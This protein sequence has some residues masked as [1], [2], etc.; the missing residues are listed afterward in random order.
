MPRSSR[1]T[2][3]AARWAVD[4][5]LALTV[6]ACLLLAVGPMLLGYRTL[7]M[8]SGSMRPLIP[9]GS[10]VVISPEPASRLAPGQIVTI[11]APIAGHPVVTH[12][13]VAVVHLAD[14][15]VAVRTRGDRNTA[16]DPWLA[17]LPGDTVWRYRAAVPYVGRLLHVLAGRF[18]R[19]T[20]G[21]LV[22]VVLATWVLSGLWLRSPTRPRRA[23]S[24]RHRRS[25]VRLSGDVPSRVL[26]A[27]SVAPT[28]PPAAPEPALAVA[29]P[30][31]P[32]PEPGPAE[33]ARRAFAARARAV[34]AC[35][36]RPPAA[37]IPPPGRA[38]AAP[39]VALV[40]APRRPDTS[41]I[42]RLRA[43]QHHAPA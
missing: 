6:A 21:V 33:V 31:A 1:G 37:R 36:A 20:A 15:H 18:A 22:P 42:Q 19:V 16:P 11:S 40:P 30:P 23:R 17:R 13:V 14:G 5:F 41:P 43:G 4:G 2:A 27:A 28:E 9:V 34:Q 35:T 8:L 12:R 29:P 7:T 3:R 24:A 25:T 39:A 38:A 32:S 10:L 26:V